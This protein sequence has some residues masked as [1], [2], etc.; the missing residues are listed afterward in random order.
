MTAGGWI[1]RKHGPLQSIPSGLH[2]VRLE[3]D[4]FQED[5]SLSC[6][7]LW[8]R[9]SKSTTRQFGQ[10]T[11]PI[12]LSSI[13]SGR[14]AC[15]AWHP[16]G[17]M[18][19]L[20][21]SSSKPPVE[22]TPTHSSTP[23]AVGANTAYEVWRTISGLEL[24]KLDEGKALHVALRILDTSV[25]VELSGVS[26]PFL[27]FVITKNGARR[28]SGPEVDALTEAM[29]EWRTAGTRSPADDTSPSG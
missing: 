2:L 24:A 11:H 13:S 21:F 27:I 9:R 22:P 25:A 12:A 17:Q 6:T 16:A 4:D 28:V 8:K 14:S 20:A 19:G 26:D 23:W 5:L 3:A 15:G 7:V 1:Q 10:R 29:D 18:K